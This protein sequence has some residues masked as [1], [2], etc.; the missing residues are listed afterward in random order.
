MFM[1]RN[2]IP[3]PE[4][5][6]PSVYYTHNDGRFG[7]GENARTYSYNEIFRDA[8]KYIQRFQIWKLW[9]DINKYNF[10]LFQANDSRSPK[11]RIWGYIRFLSETANDILWYTV[12]T[13]VSSLL[14][15]ATN[16]I[17][18]TLWKIGTEIFSDTDYI[19]SLNYEN[20]PIGFLWFDIDRAWNI[21][22][23]QLQW[24]K[25]VDETKTFFCKKNHLLNGFEWQKVLIT[26]FEDYLQ[27]NGYTG[28]LTIQCAEHN[29]YYN[30][31]AGKN[32]DH[33]NNTRRDTERNKL[34]KKHYNK[35][36]LELWYTRDII[37]PKSEYS[38]CNDFSKKI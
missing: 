17:D 26:F 5:V 1:Q 32:N 15:H 38:G 11:T 9:F 28:K 29:R 6:F 3:F 2:E 16:S 13:P 27:D 8:G 35:T 25:I 4:E 30:H 19:M 24:S 21:T 33:P 7:V 14:T 12:D 22:I 20:F 18:A 37:T 34:L 31:S 36:P 23:Q 10:S